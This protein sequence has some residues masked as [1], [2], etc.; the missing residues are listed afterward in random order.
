MLD[1]TSKKRHMTM[2]M[3]CGCLFVLILLF[4]IS[5]ANSGDDCMDNAQLGLNLTWWIGINNFAAFVLV[6]MAVGQVGPMYIAFFIGVLFVPWHIIGFIIGVT[7]Q[8][9]CVTGWHAVGVTAAIIFVIDVVLVV[10]TLLM[11]LRPQLHDN[12]TP[13]EMKPMWMKSSFYVVFLIG[14][15]GLVA[16]SL[17]SAHMKDSCL[18][19]DATGVDLAEWIVI[20]GTVT[21]GLFVILAVTGA[22]AN[23]RALCHETSVSRGLDE[24]ARGCNAA[25]AIAAA[26]WLVFLVVWIPLGIFLAASTQAACITDSGHMELAAGFFTSM[27]LPIAA[28]VTINIYTKQLMDAKGNPIG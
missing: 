25:A 6:A 26:L 12:N 14:A 21:L 5:A 17:G 9:S 18:R 4:G 23:G 13:R 11:F 28:V 20:A 19:S 22:I 16:M 1:T 15:A 7:S 8:S 24:C 2:T 27:L 10:A 3:L